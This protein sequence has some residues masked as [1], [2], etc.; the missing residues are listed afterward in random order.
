MHSL[1]EFMT[2]VTCYGETPQLNSAAKAKDVT[3]IQSQSHNKNSCWQQ[4]DKL[5]AYVTCLHE[6][7]TNSR[8]TYWQAVNMI[9][10]Q[11]LEEIKKES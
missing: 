10:M 11:I 1:K 6:R 7:V 2:A 5:W 3:N 9:D 8:Q 4:A